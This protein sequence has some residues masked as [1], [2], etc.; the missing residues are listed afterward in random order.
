MDPTVAW[1]FNFI[2]GDRGAKEKGLE[3]F[4]WAV[5]DGDVV[6]Q[7]VPEP[8]SLALFGAGLGLLGLR[9]HHRRNQSTSRS[10]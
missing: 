9:R 6:T 2:R 5:R 4:A 3:L 7:T 10:V 8:G 1:L